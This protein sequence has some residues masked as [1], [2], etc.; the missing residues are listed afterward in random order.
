MEINMRYER[1]IR[2]QRRTSRNRVR[3]GLLGGCLLLVPLFG[4]ECDES[5]PNNTFADANLLRASEYG[6]STISPIGDAD[7]W[8]IPNAHAG[9]LIFALADPLGSSGSLD[10]FLEIIANDGTTFL[11]SDSD[12]GSAATPLAAAVA[13]VTTQ[14]GNVF[15][16]VS[17]AG[18][19]A[20]ISACRLWQAVVAPSDVFDEV[21]PN[22]TA[23]TANR[24]TASVARG[25]VISGSGDADFYRIPVLGS[26]S[27]IV[28]ICD[29]DP[30]GDGLRT[31]TALSLIDTDGT[32]V[33]PN[34]T[35][36]ND[37]GRATNVVGSITV[38]APGT[39]FLRVADGAAGADSDYRLVVLING[40]ICRDADSDDIPDPD[41]NCP[42]VANPGQADADGDG[43]GDVCDDCPASVIK[44]TAGT[45]GCD[46][47]DVDLNG[48][49]QADCNTT[50]AARE[51]LVRRGVLLVTDPTNR[52]VLALD[53]DD[54]DV[55]DANFIPPDAVN[56]TTPVAAILGP[57]RNSV[58]V[59]DLTRH[60]VQRYDLDGNFLGTFAPAG[61]PDAAIMQQPTGMTLLPDGSLLVCVQAGPNQDAV[62][63][64]DSNGNSLGNLI[65]PAAGG[66]DAPIDVL[67]REDGHILV[68]GEGSEKIH[69]FDA[70]G[71]PVA[72]FATVDEGVSQMVR[73]ADGH[74]LVA[75]GDFLLRGVIELDAAGARL[76]Q[77]APAGLSGFSGVAELGNGQLVVAV[78]TRHVTGGSDGNGPGGVFTMDRAGNLLARKLKG[79]ECGHVKFAIVDRDG[80]GVGDEL[81]ECPD[82]P[83]KSAPGQC[84][85]GN[86]DTDSDGDG[87]ADCVDGCPADANKTAPGT[88]GCGTADTDSDGDGVA[89]CLDDCPADADKTAPGECGCG[90]ADTDSDGDGVLDCLDDCP[91]DPNK[92][93]L[94]TCGCSV[95]DTDRD[96]D[97][98]PD[99]N[100]RCPDD[101][102][103]FAPG[104]CGCGS[105]EADEDENGFPD[106]LDDGVDNGGVAPTACGSCGA[107]LS[108]LM[109][110][111]LMMTYRTAYG[112]VARSRAKR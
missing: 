10:T 79:F 63:H 53:P 15:A 57:D 17:E 62:V 47:P 2:N 87:T 103:K 42:D 94:G 101:P 23:A 81:D 78:D 22:N 6:F 27:R 7:I 97:G 111:G 65:A 67:R 14:D 39:Y 26:N 41:D 8:R 12:S 30:D 55:L 93:G 109:L 76:A 9:D 85:C 102:A 58:L 98:V 45:C 49:G 13:T 106:C 37:P 32:T 64:F 82:D 36:N 86:A 105:S 96:G 72:D 31:N 83:N 16:R 48:D 20:T 112:R 54:G 70:S 19:D 91:N 92:T 59:S 95:A 11:E 1:T 21:E 50:D 90:R 35:G 46:H 88:C 3:V 25:N 74:L 56:L 89:D 108:P 38:A 18:N 33:L 99:C 66:L 75:S 110:V 69:E 52:R 60:V 104:L 40:A 100:D 43:V 24:L 44:T 29:D 71:A 51:M 80:D 77:L 73:A 68:A 84:G 4:A 34:G 5:E 28:V 61:G 107:G